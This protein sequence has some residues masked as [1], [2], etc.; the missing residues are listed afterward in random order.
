MDKDILYQQEKSVFIMLVLAILWCAPNLLLAFMSGSL[1][2]T[3]DIP[4]NFRI[5]LT[6]ILS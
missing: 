4:D 2:L 6:N 5:I 1:V 3:S